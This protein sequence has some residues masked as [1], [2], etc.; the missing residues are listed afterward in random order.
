M[1]DQ[2]PAHNRHVPGTGHMGGGIRQ[3]TAVLKIRLLHPQARGPLIHHAD[4]FR[5][6]S[7]Y[8]FC[9]GDAGIIAGSDHDAL[10]QGFHRL[11][12]PFLQKHLGTAHG[13]GISAGYHLV[14]HLNLPALQGVENQDQRHDLGDAGG[15]PLFI[16]VFLVN[17]LPGGCL[18]QNRAGRGQG[19][20]L[21]GEN[22]GRKG[23]AACPG[24]KGHKGRQK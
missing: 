8:V 23:Q 16:P 10:D 21:L 18:H 6:T 12:F 15:T 24:R 17:N 5:F 13:F 14:G 3:P 22:S 11:D 4:K 20:W 1:I 2:L 9:H 19:D 7:R